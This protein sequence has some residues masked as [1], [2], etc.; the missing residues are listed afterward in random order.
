MNAK[1][2]S[3]LLREESCHDGLQ[4]LVLDHCG[5]KT[6]A[7]PGVV[8]SLIKAQ[9]RNWWWE[10]SQDTSIEVD[11]QDANLWLWLCDSGRFGVHFE[12]PE[13]DFW[14]ID[15]DHV[16]SEGTS[17][18]TRL[19]GDVPK[20]LPLATVSWENAWLA[21]AYLYKETKPS[22]RLQWREQSELTS[23]YGVESV[24]ES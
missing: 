14:A 11:G 16:V 18:C 9:P 3:D 8:Y 4:K 19:G 17:E 15:P 5:G 12:T 24:M 1:F 13:A 20:I 7:H 2:E 22:P 10:G 23:M 21:V 6:D